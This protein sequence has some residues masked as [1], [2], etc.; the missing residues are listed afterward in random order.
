MLRSDTLRITPE[1]LPRP[2]EK[3]SRHR[4]QYK[5]HSNSVAA[6]DEGGA[7]IGTVFETRARRR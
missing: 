1:I 6:F 4:G 3:G 5:T 2:S 7:Q